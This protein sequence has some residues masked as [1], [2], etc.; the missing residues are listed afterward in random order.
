MPQKATASRQ[1]SAGELTLSPISELVFLD[2]YAIKDPTKDLQV[3]D[4]VVALV[5]DDPRFPQ[6]EVAIVRAIEGDT[7][8]LEVKSSG[9]LIKQERKKIDKP[10]E[11]HPSQMWDR[12]ARAI[13]QVEEA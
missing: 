4:V 12:M 10:L 5:K 11:T 1:P 8:T 6:R 9:E 13:V 7:V 3:G 2:R